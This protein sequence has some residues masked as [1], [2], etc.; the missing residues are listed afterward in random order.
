M[1]TASLAYCIHDTE[2]SQVG[3]Y[4]STVA[5]AWELGVGALLALLTPELS[6]L[7]ERTRASAS[8]IGVGA[9]LIAGVAFTD[10]TRFPG[11]AALLPVCGGALVVLSGLNGMP[12]YGA[13]ELLRNRPVQLIGD[14]SYA[15]Y[16]WH[17]PILVIVAEYL[18]HPLTVTQNLGLLLCGFA[19]SVFTYMT[20]ENPIRH[21]RALAMPRTALALWPATVMMVL[22]LATVGGGIR[23]GACVGGAG[24]PHDR[25]E[26]AQCVSAGGAAK[27]HARQ[28]G[29]AD[30]QGARSTGLGAEQGRADRLCDGRWAG[31]SLHA[32]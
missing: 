3:A 30:P 23:T 22:G 10:T 2:T 12:R 31:A 26:A 11:Y 9:I 1:C 14:T 21:A 7:S 16:L 6:R 29:I 32:R 13:G 18:G 24:A 28:A 5:R 4:F 25:R 19:L 8:W 17:W 15:F 20:F 27:R